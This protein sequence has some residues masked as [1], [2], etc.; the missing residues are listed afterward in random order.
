MIRAL[1]FL[2][3]I[4]AVRISV[5]GPIADY[6][7][8]GYE[9][10]AW[11]TSLTALVGVFPQGEHHFSTAPGERVY[12]VRN[13]EPLL[14]V[15]RLGAT[16]QYHLGKDGGVESIAIGVPYERRD[17]L[18]GTLLSL[19]G[20]YASQRV[21]GSAISYYWTRDRGISLSTRSSQSPRNGIL[22]FWI[23]R[24][25]SDKPSSRAK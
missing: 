9:G 24:I 11:G 14:G 19:F 10:V 20:G 16:I 6:F 2:G 3:L 12:I 7:S 15:P 5:A 22:E 17:Q 1:V 4:F 8:S 13:D 18:M 23:G 21:V 25:A